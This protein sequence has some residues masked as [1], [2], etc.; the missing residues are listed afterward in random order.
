LLI[1]GDAGD[2]ALGVERISGVGGIGLGML[3]GST[4][5]WLLGGRGGRGG[6]ADGEESTNG[7]ANGGEGDGRVGR[8]AVTCGAGSGGAGANGDVSSMVTADGV[9]ACAIASTVSAT[10]LA[11]RSRSASRIGEEKRPPALVPFVTPAPPDPEG[12]LISRALIDCASSAL[13]ALMW[14]VMRTL[15]AR[16]ETVTSLAVT[17]ASSARAEA[18]GRRVASSS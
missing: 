7:F 18:M 5:V 13:A 10:P 2:G 16:T 9:G 15:A 12:P 4:A 1:G 6:I 3:D 8:F 17:P 11:A 14:T